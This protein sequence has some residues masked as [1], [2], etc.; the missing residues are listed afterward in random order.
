MIV[1]TVLILDL[2]DSAEVD[3]VDRMLAG[4]GGV[5]ACGSMIF[6]SQLWTDYILPFGFWESFARDAG[7]AGRSAPAVAFLGWSGLALMGFG[8]LSN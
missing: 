3:R 1:A 8:I 7:N 6:F 5:V 4:V 2:Y